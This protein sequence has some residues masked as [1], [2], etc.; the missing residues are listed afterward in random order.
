VARAVTDSLG[1]EYFAED[2]GQL[3]QALFSALWL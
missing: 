2:W 3:N 1:A